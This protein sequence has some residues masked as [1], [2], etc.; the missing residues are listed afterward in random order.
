MTHA[1]TNPATEGSGRQFTRAQQLTGV[2]GYIKR[3][4]P[5]PRAELRRLS[6][7]SAAV[8]PKVFWDIVDRYR[9]RESD[10]TY[11]ISVIPLMVRHPHVPTAPGRALARAK[12]SAAR[13]ERWLRLDRDGARRSAGRVLSQLKQGG[14]DWVQFGD[15]LRDWSD[16][17]RRRLARQFFRSPNDDR[18]PPPTDETR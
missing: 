2:A 17:G 16:D 8:P 6:P 14:L 11:W 5:G 15:L 4:R 18:T 10:E 13:V 12:V 9:I 1:A 7:D 3:L